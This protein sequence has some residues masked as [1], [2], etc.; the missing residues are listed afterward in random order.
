MKTQYFTIILLV[1]S[2]LSLSCS[3][4]M[5]SANTD[6]HAGMNH[7]A[8][9]NPT[10]PPG[11]D[12]GGMDHTMQS[13]PNAATA[14]YDLQFLDTMIE[15]HKGAV[16]M[17]GPATARALHPEIKTL[18]TDI[19]SSQQNEIGQMKVW[20][21]KWFP[22]AAAALNME[23]P[24]MAD[25]M[26]GMDMKILTIVSGNDFDLAF[27]KQMVPHHAGAVMMAND[28]LQRSSKPEIKTLAAAIIKTQESE[29]KQMKEWQTAWSKTK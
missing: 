26:K 8:N 16:M 2:A 5:P 28:A 15:H 14:A 20:R 22:G 4:Q 13:S 11:A 6:P 27:I 9:Q 29:I 19:I 1:I 7:N 18:A 21:D 3:R 23:M 24:G 25:S 10:V 12:H 17:A